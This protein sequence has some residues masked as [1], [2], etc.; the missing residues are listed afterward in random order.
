[1]KELWY[2]IFDVK[3]YDDAEDYTKARESGI[4]CAETKIDAM[5]RLDNW[6]GINNIYDIHIYDVE[7]DTNEILFER[8]FPGLI[9]LMKNPVE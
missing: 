1:M 3:F 6:F 7:M 4:I 9:K 2:Y 5:Q 8:N